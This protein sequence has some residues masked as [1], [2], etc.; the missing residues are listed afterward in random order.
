MTMD[1]GPIEATGGRA[2]RELLATLTRL[3]RT[4]R[5]ARVERLIAGSWRRHGGS[6]GRRA[7]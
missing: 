1:P 4:A 5:E 2:L 3:T 6:S 7:A